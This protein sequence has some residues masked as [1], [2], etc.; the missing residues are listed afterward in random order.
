MFESRY[1]SEVPPWLHFCASGDFFQWLEA[2]PLRKTPAGI[3]EWI[4]GF[5][6]TVDNAEEAQ[7][8]SQTIVMEDHFRSFIAAIA[9]NDIV[10]SDLLD[11]VPNTPIPLKMLPKKRFS[12]A[13]PTIKCEIDLTSFTANQPI[14]E[15][16][17]HRV[18]Q[19]ETVQLS[20][21]F[22]TS[23]LKL[24][25]MLGIYDC[26]TPA[27]KEV[28][29]D[30]EATLQMPCGEKVGLRLLLTSTHAGP[31]DAKAAVKLTRT[32]KEKCPASKAHPSR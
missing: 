12:K 20:Y 1:S 31:D 16:T 29:S 15:P 19:G 11:N 4:S 2:G 18:A 22:S 17:H 6:V 9:E 7:R 13:A 23:K 27:W 24:K 32:A 26:T 28:V 30:S 21:E 5:T 8:L 10:D 14:I 3:W 25:Y